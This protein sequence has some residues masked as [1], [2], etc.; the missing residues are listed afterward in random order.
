MTRVRWQSIEGGYRYG[1]GWAAE[2]DG[3]AVEVTAAVCGGDWRA[4]AA[5]GRRELETWHATAAA[6]KRAAVAHARV[7]CGRG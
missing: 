6:A 4:W 1:S 7:L 3:V 2:L 5:R